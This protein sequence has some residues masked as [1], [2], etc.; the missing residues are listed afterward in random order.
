MATPTL[1]IEIE[2]GPDED[3]EEIEQLRIQL[4][5]E[6]LGLDVD[7]V[8]TIEGKPAPEGTKA[9]DA[10]A[11]GALLVKLGP[12]V[13]SAVTGALQ[14]WAARSGGRTITVQ[15]G[16]GEAITLTGANEEERRQ[17]VDAWLARQQQRLADA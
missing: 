16:E 12:A 2:A 1:L 17:L 6:L 11:V 3:P 9:I 15:M 14:S 7:S 10:I 8:E 4:R 5:D 13:L